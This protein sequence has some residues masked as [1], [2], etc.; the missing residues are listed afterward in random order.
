[1]YCGSSPTSVLRSTLKLVEAARP[2]LAWND[3][4]GVA[5]ASASVLTL[6]VTSTRLFSFLIWYHFA[7]LVL[8]LAFLGFTAGGLIVARTASKGSTDPRRLLSWLGFT[9]GAA[10]LGCYFTL[11]NLPF[12]A[13]FASDFRALAIFVVAVLVL[14]IPFVCLGAYICFALSVWAERVALLYAVDLAGSAAGCVLAAGLLNSLGVPAAFLANGLLAFAAGAFAFAPRVRKPWQWLAIACAAVA[15][16]VVIGG[17]TQELRSWVY[18]KTSK[19]YPKLPREFVVARKS[20]SLATVEMFRFPLAS[21]ATLWGLSPTYKGAFPD[22]VGFA[23]DGWALTAVYKRADVDV[24]N[25]VLDYL[26][27]ALPYR[28]YPPQDALVIGPGGGLD[29]LTALRFGAKH[30]TG[31]EINPIIVDAVKHE[32][33]EIAGHLYQDPR[34]EIHNAEGRHF[35]KRDERKYDLIQLSGVDTYAASQAGAFA[36]HENY[37]YTVEAMNDYLDALRP[38]GMLTFTRWLYVPPRQ[39]IRLCAIAD[40]ALRQRGVAH[41]E[42]HIVVFESNDFTITMIKRTEFLPA[43]TARIERAVADQQF[44]LLYAPH[45]RVNPL[46]ARWGENP[47][48]Q[49]W[50][51][52]IAKFI[53]EYPLDVRPTTDDRPFFFEYQR[54]GG[55]FVRENLF[56]TQNAQI[57]LLETLGVCGLLCAVILWIARRRHRDLGAGLGVRAHVYFIALGL[58]YIFVENALVQR[59][60]LFLGSPVYALTVILFAL[61]ASSGLGSAIVARSARLHAHARAVMWAAAAVLVIYAFALRPVLEPLLGLPLA[62]RILIVIL[63]VA[64]LG[65]LMGM[66]FPLALRAVSQVDSRLLAWAWVTNGAASVLGGIFTMMLAMSA[67]FSSVFLSAALLYLVASYTYSHLTPRAAAVS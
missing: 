26:P 12:A 34:V 54:W 18:L 22:I 28:L 8:S 27:A 11:A 67:G 38:D 59:I 16:V 61:L 41:P 37:L 24:S 3:L 19:P 14:L 29:I 5:L 56:R 46:K 51:Q 6:Q 66:P 63:A 17:A 50:D 64:P 13:H 44:R 60:I 55:T 45:T 1:L 57:V 21:R 35:L 30:V 62:V 47:F 65:V 33:A 49:M 25:S 40:Q 32:Y 9:A 53:A 31:V 20:N 36:L 7:F 42:R 4:L 39:T 2:S 43:D 10:T 58:G 23:I 52:G 48:Y 15:W